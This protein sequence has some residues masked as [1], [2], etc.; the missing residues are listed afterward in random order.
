MRL[1]PYV[2]DLDFEYVRKWVTDE[3]THLFWSAM[4]F[5]YPLQQEEMD[6]YLEQGARERGETAFVVTRE[7]GT[8][9]GF[10]VY[11]LNLSDNAGFLRFVILDGAVR[12]KGYGTQMMKLAVNYAFR[13]TGAKV[14]R[15]NVFADNEPAIRCYEK[16]GFEVT[17][18]LKVDFDYNGQSYRRYRMKITTPC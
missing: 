1:R 6:R 12:G 18:V 17:E 10:F 2:S 3:K 11:S 16:V 4:S 7:D 9:I 15:L 8:P 13:M 14:V 5:A